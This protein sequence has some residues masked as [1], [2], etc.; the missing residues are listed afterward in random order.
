MRDW[1]MLDEWRG[2]SVTVIYMELTASAF[3]FFE[4]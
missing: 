2:V 3:R 4:T 1:E